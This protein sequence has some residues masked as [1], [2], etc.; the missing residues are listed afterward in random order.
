MQKQVSIIIPAYNVEQYV[1]VCIDSIIAQTYNN[2]EIIV[3]NDGSTDN[4]YEIL[5]QKSKQSNVKIRLFSQSNSGQSVARNRGIREAKGSYIIF[6]DSDDWLT[7]KFAVEKMV[8]KIENENADYVQCSL[9]FVKGS[10]HY[11][12]LVPSKNAISGSQ[13]LIDTLN[14]AD[15]Y[16]APWGKIYSAKFLQENNLYFQEGLVN[17][18][19]GFSIMIAAKAHKVAFLS[20]I[21]YSSL[22][23]DGSTS[24]SSFIRM[25]DTLHQI[26]TITCAELKKD[27]LYNIEVQNYFEARYIRSMLY[28]L[29]QTAQRSD[30]STYK[31]DAQYCF[32]E[33]EYRN[34]FKSLRFLPVKYRILAQISYSPTLFYMVANCLKTLGYKMH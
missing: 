30:Y 15:L 25:F 13:A 10:K 24:R 11:P 17:E 23:R 14:V 1:G 27:N 12:Y 4:T 8:N 34:M 21:V 22:E 19:T 6:V 18:D 31:K 29:M 16:T 9:E 3:I 20:E 26:M 33:T 5:A 32:E 2:I 28:N 7:S